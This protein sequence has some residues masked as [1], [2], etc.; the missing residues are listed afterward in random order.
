MRLL[1]PFERILDALIDPAQRE[2]AVVWLLTAYCAAWSLYGALAKGSQDVHFDM[3]EMVA[4]SRDAGIGT[5]KHPPLSAWLGRAWFT[6]FPPA[7]WSYYLFALVLTAF[8][9]LAPWRLSSHHPHPQ[10]PR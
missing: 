10:H 9:L 1:A 7:Y 8:S 5:P 6:G 2:R 4:W 3:G